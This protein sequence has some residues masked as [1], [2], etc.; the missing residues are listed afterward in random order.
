MV[1]FGIASFALFIVLQFKS[2]RKSI[3]LCC[4]TK[5]T[6]N[7]APPPLPADL[8]ICPSVEEEKKRVHKEKTGKCALVINDLTKTFGGYTAVNELCLAVDRR[9]C[10]GLLGVNGAGKTTTFNILTGQS[11]ATSGEATIGGR[12]VT[13]LVAIGYCPQYDA[14]LPDMTGRET[15]EI[16]AQMHGFDHYKEKV[17]LVLKCVGM[18]GNANKRI[19]YC[20][21]GQKRKISVGVA[22]LSPTQ[23]IIL[24]EPTAGVDP[25]ARREIWELLLWCRENSKSAIVL[26]SHSMDE[27]EALCSRIA[28]LNKG[29]VIAIGTSQ[30]LK[31][32]YGNNYTM[33][34]TLNN[35]EQR[36]DIVK[37]VAEKIPKSVFKTAETNR[38]LNLKWQTKP[39]EPLTN[40]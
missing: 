6:A 14:L 15:L 13:E 40:T 7:N 10:F 35:D 5:N 11:F 37:R 27:C 4:S 29:Q 23:L 26:T 21:G 38:T 3:S 18:E 9:E 31:S 1:A 8:P 16:L 34:L 20:S 39:N 28:V 2:V 24:D 32:L 30:D 19:R 22:L 12:D 33:I 17:E 36:E 25:Q